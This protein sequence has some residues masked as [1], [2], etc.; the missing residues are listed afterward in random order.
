MACGREGEKGENASK[1][2]ITH[3]AQRLKIITHTHIYSKKKTHTDLNPASM[4]NTLMH[5]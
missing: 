1:C 3:R 4:T 5:V 2:H